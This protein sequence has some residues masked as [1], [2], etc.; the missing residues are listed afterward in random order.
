MHV[1][2]EG[3]LGDGGAALHEALADGL[4]DLQLGATLAEVAGNAAR[5]LRTIVTD[6]VRNSFVVKASVAAAHL[7]LAAKGS[8]AGRDL[9]TNHGS[10]CTVNRL[11]IHHR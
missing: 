8:V 9:G 7:A 2:G 11:R 5:M 1:L 6:A 10:S 4:L 3:R